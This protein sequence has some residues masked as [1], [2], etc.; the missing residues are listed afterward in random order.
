M[1]N[2]PSP[3]SQNMPANPAPLDLDAYLRRIH[4]SGAR[5]PTLETLTHLHQQH[6]RT[7]PFENLD[8]VLGR[9]IRID[10]PSIERKLVHERR[11]GYCFEQNRLL[12]AVLRALGFTVSP[13]LARVRWQRPADPIGPLTHMLLR[14]TTSDGGNF[15]ADVGFGSMS[16]VRPLRLECGVEQGAGLE[17]RRL[18]GAGNQL[19]QQARLG[20]AWADVYQFSLEE[21]PEIDFELGNWFT[22]THPQ[23]HF[24]YTVIA[25]RAGEGCR[26]TLR[27]REFNTRY[28]DGRVVQRLVESP[29]ELLAILG[30]HFDLHLPPGTRFGKPG[31][32]WPA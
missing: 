28:A 20:D 5:A 13:L 15:L 25:S 6:V 11:G 19:V 7:I 14:V 10:I 29:D 31:T 16:L 22:S 21:P 9:G 27:D 18:I 12:A 4:F 24:T 2:R 30:Q 26:H 17:P 23:S 32:P 1:P 8:V 3:C